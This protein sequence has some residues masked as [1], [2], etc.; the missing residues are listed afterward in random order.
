MVASSA[1]RS[2]VEGVAGCTIVVAV[3]DSARVAVV[4]VAG[5]V[6]EVVVRCAAVGVVVER[7]IAD[8]RRAG[9]TPRTEAQPDAVETA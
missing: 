5:A 3:K 8:G 2:A 4:E 6:V 9:S 7:E 1:N